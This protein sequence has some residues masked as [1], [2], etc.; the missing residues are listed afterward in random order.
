VTDDLRRDLGDLAGRVRDHD[1]ALADLASLGVDVER[2]GEKVTAL[3]EELGDG[4]SGRGYKPAP[5]LR[6]ADLQD[7]ERAEATERI[8]EWVDT[9]ARPYLGAS[10]WSDCLYEPEHGEVL[11][12]LDV[13]RECWMALYEPVKRPK[14]VAAAEAEFLV[15]IWPPILQRVDKLTTGCSKHRELRR[16][17]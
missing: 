2:L 7:D 13:A 15:R 16:V 17:S 4:G 10:E 8:R 1:V 6:W 11:M 9:I 14:T 5:N 3:E 12:L